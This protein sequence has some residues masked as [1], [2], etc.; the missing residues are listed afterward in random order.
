MSMCRPRPLGI[1]IGCY[2]RYLPR[3]THTYPR[4]GRLYGNSTARSSCS[5]HTRNS[6]TG[7]PGLD[8]LSFDHR[9]SFARLLIRRCGCER[10]CSGFCLLARSFGLF[11]TLRARLNAQIGAQYRADRAGYGC[12]SSRDVGSRVVSE[13]SE[14]EGGEN[15]RDC[16]HDRNKSIPPPS[17]LADLCC[18]WDPE[19]LPESLITALRWPVTA[20]LWGRLHPR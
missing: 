15:R 7:S 8:R 9:Q 10:H 17:R 12:Q 1:S 19:A 11:L 6:S 5:R 20:R 13:R 4:S 3:V 16:H 14:D 2:R 18:T